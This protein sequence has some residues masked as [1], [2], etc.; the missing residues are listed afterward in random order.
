MRGR[1]KFYDAN[2]HFGFII[3]DGG[4]A[5]DVFVGEHEVSAAGLTHLVTAARVEF[6]IMSDDRGRRRA[7]AIRVIDAAPHI[8]TVGG[9]NG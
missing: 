5:G 1:V 6:E 9:R 7:A 4:A 3:P 2:R 8:N